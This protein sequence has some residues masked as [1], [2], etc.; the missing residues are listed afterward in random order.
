MKKKVISVTKTLVYQEYLS[1]NN[2]TFHMEEPKTKTSKRLVPI[3]SH[4]L[5]KEKPLKFEWDENKNSNNIM[6]HKVSFEEAMTVFK[7]KKAVLLGIS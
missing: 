3:S 4:S 6:K 2:K 7:D 5:I 1:D